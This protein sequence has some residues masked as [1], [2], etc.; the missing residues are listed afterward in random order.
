[1]RTLLIRYF[2][3]VALIGSLLWV[4][5]AQGYRIITTPSV[6]P[7]V[8]KVE[9][10]HGP[11][12]QGQ[13]VWLCPPDTQLFR[14]AKQRGYIPEG[15]CPG[16]YRHLLKPVAAVTSD[17]ILIKKSGIFVNGEF[18][19]NSQVLKRDQ[20]GQPLPQ[21]ISTQYMVQPG[22]IWVISPFDLKSFDS[23][24]FHGVS[25]TQLKG[26]ARPVLIFND[27]HPSI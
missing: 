14:L 5:Y 24:Y 11:I 10:I 20:K 23:R 13:F 4:F 9:P 2:S 15:E 12:R 21:A 19:Q 16:G 6:P 1:M 26:I 18:I 3:G 7:G 17:K 27:V 8:W 25:T 22:F